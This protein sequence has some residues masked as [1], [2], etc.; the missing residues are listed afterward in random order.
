MA[1]LVAAAATGI[2]I[3]LLGARPG[4]GEMNGLFGWRLGLFLLVLV[5]HASSAFVGG[6]LALFR[7]TRSAGLVMLAAGIG[8]W[9]AFILMSTTIFWMG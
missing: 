8:G 6:L 9:L 5:L 4:R 3:A 7:R 1:F 2:L